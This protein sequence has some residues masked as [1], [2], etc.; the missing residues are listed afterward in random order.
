V[1]GSGGRSIFLLKWKSGKKVL[2]LSGQY[3]FHSCNFRR[4][5]RRF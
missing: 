5:V 2:G 1:E 4:A 3:S